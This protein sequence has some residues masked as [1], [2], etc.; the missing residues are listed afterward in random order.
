[1][2]FKWILLALLVPA[3]ARAQTTIKTTTQLRSD[4]DGRL[5]ATLRPGTP[6]KPVDTK[7][8]WTQVLLEGYVHRSVIGGKRDTFAIS[9][10]V[11]DTN[12]RAAPSPTGK[13]LARLEEGM[14]LIRESQRGDW[15]RVHRL[16]WVRS[17]AL[18]TPKQVASA[19]PA[20]PSNEHAA[21][22]PPVDTTTTGEDDGEADTG[23]PASVLAVGHRTQLRVAPDGPAIAVLD[24]NARVATLA[25]ERGW[26]RVQ[27]EGWVRATELVP[28]D[29]TVLTAISAADLR[30]EPSKFQ[31]VTVRWQVQKIALQTADPLR[32]DMAPNEPYLLARGPGAERSLLYLALPPSLVEQARRIEPLA[33]LIVVAR[34]RAGRSE[35]AGVPLLD[36]QSIVE[37]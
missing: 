30:A 37:R 4:P 3:A 32:R 28:E 33:T 12:L 26:V 14:G 15:V 23:A 31:G 9:A 2:R 8:P 21:A 34:V 1:M 19:K 36:V 11:D 6:V 18:S 13:V 22:P 35:P 24:S 25:R 7:G 17:S 29:T 16:A 10:R 27:V 20:A 5:L